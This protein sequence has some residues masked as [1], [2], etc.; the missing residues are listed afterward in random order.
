MF[1]EQLWPHLPTPLVHL[2][3]L[4]EAVAVFTYSSNSSS[5]ALSLA[6]IVVLTISFVLGSI[7]ISQ[8]FH[9]E[10]IAVILTLAFV[11]AAF[12]AQH[13]SEIYEFLHLHTE[14]AM[15][16]ARIIYGIVWFVL[17]AIAIAA[18]F[19]NVGRPVTRAWPLLVMVT[20][21]AVLMPIEPDAFVMHQPTW[22]WITRVVTA[23]VIFQLVTLADA[24]VVVEGI[25]YDRIEQVR[26]NQHRSGANG[27]SMSIMRVPTAQEA[28]LPMARTAIW[29]PMTL[30]VMFV[31]RAVILLAIIIIAALIRTLM[32]RWRRVTQAHLEFSALHRVLHKASTIAG[33]EHL[34]RAIY[35]LESQVFTLVRDELKQERRAL[36]ESGNGELVLNMAEQ[37]AIDNP[38]SR[39]GRGPRLRGTGTINDW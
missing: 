38:T 4:L 11:N 26:H 23:L 30:W 31:P 17:V 1:L 34:T 3:V 14:E 33:I 25:Y 39:R 20:L 24:V 21:V 36:V 15:L 28:D 18:Y 16:T 19:R 2:L 35:D 29:L 13:T 37:E 7:T 22:L 5:L 12:L 27:S 8:P 32:I 10:R 9:I 6:L